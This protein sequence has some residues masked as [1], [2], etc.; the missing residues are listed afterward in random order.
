MKEKYRIVVPISHLKTKVMSIIQI[1]CEEGKH[2]EIHNTY[3]TIEFYYRQ[4]LINP[5]IH[6]M[7][8]F[9]ME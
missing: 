1:L 2:D 6:A 5:T 8:L 3:S 7:Q 4:L 9:E